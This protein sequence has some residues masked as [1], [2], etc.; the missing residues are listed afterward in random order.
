MSPA[1]IKAMKRRLLKRRLMGVKPGGALLLIAL[2]VP[3]W[4]QDGNPTPPTEPKDDQF[5]FRTTLNLVT[6]PVTVIGRDKQYVAGL[7]KDQFHVY[8]NDQEQKIVGFDVSFLP[9]S[10]VVCVETSG[11]IEGLMQQVRKTGIVFT[12]MV[13]GA[14]PDSEAALITFD[15]RVQ[16]A[17]E[18]TKDH[19]KLID[20]MNKKIKP[21][22]DGT[23]MADAVMD[24][25]RMLRSRPQDHR[26]VIVLVSENRNNGSEVRLGEALRDSQLYDILIYPI[27]L[28]TAKGKLTH[29]A[30]EKRSAFPPGVSPMP[31]PPGVVYTPNTQAQN[32]VEV[33]NTLPYIVEAV[34]GVKNLIFN[35]PMQLLSQG[36]GGKQIGTYT[37]SGLEDAISDVGEELRSQYLLSYR[38]NNLN[39]GGFH[40]IR[41][42]VA[43]EGL[44]VRTRPGYWLGP[45]PKETTDKEAT[46][47]GAQSQKPR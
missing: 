22:A 36:T 24:A 33:V 42:E 9:M 21:G 4:A 34:R 25:V 15:S 40:T 46:D 18:F 5:R 8:D 28:S 26:K 29:P 14:Q 13:L 6:A 41:V 39:T 11:R 12:D 32:H 43:V 2:L 19:D 23:R 7:E 31:M 27:R 16:V 47:P 20:A 10:M 44:K 3:V 38:P 17:Q 35:D 30:E 45:I 37:E 1:C